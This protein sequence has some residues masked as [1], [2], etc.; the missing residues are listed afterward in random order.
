MLLDNKFKTILDTLDKPAS[1][2]YAGD[3]QLCYLTYEPYL[4]LEVKRKLS[5]WL[6][7]AKGYQF[8][9]SVLSMA[10][11]TNDFFRN[12]PRRNGWPVPN[13]SANFDE[14]IDFFKDDLGSMIISNKVIEKAILEKQEVCKHQKRPLLILSDLEA[15]HPFTRFGPIEQNIYTEIEIPFIILYPGSLSGSSLEFLGYYPPDGNYRSKHF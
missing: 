6:I 7:L 14:I 1:S 15:L 9:C 3:K 12:N 2:H 4:T 11:I 10:Q 8:E 5:N 13:T